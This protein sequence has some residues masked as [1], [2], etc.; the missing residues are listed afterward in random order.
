MPIKKRFLKVLLCHASMDKQIVRDLYKRLESEP[1]IDTWLDE[2]KILPGQDWNVEI[3]KGVENAD[4]VIVCL[5]NNSV[6]KEGYVQRELRYVLDIALE[7][8][9]GTIFVIPLRLDK[10]EVPRRL[11]GSQYADYFPEDARDL[12]FVRLRTSLELR[13]QELGVRFRKQELKPKSTSPTKRSKRSAKDGTPRR[14]R[15]LRITNVPKESIR[16][17][18]SRE[19]WSNIE[20]VCIPSGKFVMGS[21][22]TNHL[23]TRDEFPQHAIDLSYD[24]WIARFPVTNRQYFLFVE[25]KNKDH[26]VGGWKK[27]PHHP[28]VY[29]NWSEAM[30]YCQWL[31]ELIGDHLPS[32][33]AVRLPTEPEWEKAA[34]GIDGNEWP[35]GN[36][37][38]AARCNT[39]ETGHNHTTHVGQYSPAGDSPYGCAD[40]VGNVWE[41]THTLFKS[42]PYSAVDDREY[43]RETPNRHVLR[44]GSFDDVVDYTRCAVRV[45][46]SRLLGCGYALGFRV[47][48]S[49]PLA[50]QS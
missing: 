45:P 19:T 5:S 31:N 17:D 41:W 34:R 15:A 44:G 33:L 42:Y 6:T 24:Y 2:E 29:I 18:N 36:T 47:A 13:A 46:G 40:M 14:S 32:G 50:R 22:K 12:A 49:V 23:A 20:F 16:G 11:R 1:W 48:I 9:E 38:D 27:K 25:A 35:W 21:S 30:A 26:P 7:K 37:F 39:S 10:C 28:V 4:A 3:E 8:P 43:A